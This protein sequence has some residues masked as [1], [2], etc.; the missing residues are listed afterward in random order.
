MASKNEPSR[1]QSAIWAQ[2]DK[3]Q[4]VVFSTSVQVIGE[5]VTA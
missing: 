1:Q 3:P 2:E 5:S 4:D